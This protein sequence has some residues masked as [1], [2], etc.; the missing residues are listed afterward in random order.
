MLV[1]LP[2]GLWVFAL[3]SDIIYAMGYWGVNG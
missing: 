1:A 3:A 2:I